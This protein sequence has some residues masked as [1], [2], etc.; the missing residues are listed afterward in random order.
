M[1]SRVPDYFYKTTQIVCVTRHDT[2]ADQ[3]DDVKN[4]LQL[5][6]LQLLHWYETFFGSKASEYPKVAIDKDRKHEALGF[7]FA[8]S[9][10]LNRLLFCLDPVDNAHCEET[11]QNSALKILMIAK[12]ELSAVSQAELFMAI[13]FK[14][15][16]V[17]LATA[18]RWRDWRMSVC[19]KSDLLTESLIMPKDMFV[20]WCQRMGWETPRQH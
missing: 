5:L 8:V 15:A 1:V 17:T 13:K 10:I 6:R 2:P 16:K 3:V 14:V 11:A 9:I 18:E 7:S 19:A 12:Q 4:N 20:D